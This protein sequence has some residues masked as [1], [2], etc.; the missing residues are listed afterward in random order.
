MD[1]DNMF[2]DAAGPTIAADE[3]KLVAETV[4]LLVLVDLEVLVH[5]S[6]ALE[7]KGACC[8]GYDGSCQRAPFYLRPGLQEG[9]CILGLGHTV[10]TLDSE[11]YSGSHTPCS[12]N[13][14]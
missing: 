10:V 6:L 5:R 11:A 7:L 2:A 1:L 12:I 14:P 13:P 3:T 4:H 8:A 9:V